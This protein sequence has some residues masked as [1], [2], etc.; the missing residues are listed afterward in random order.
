MI[1]LF[2]ILWLLLGIIAVWRS[3]H[4]DL[5]YWYNQF[6]ESYWDFDKENGFSAIR[7][8]IYTSPLIILG[9]LFSLLTLELTSKDNC[10][11]FTTRNK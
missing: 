11:W 9:G 7:L 1:T 2:I 8:L 6:N 3:Y 5:K 4:G 10:W